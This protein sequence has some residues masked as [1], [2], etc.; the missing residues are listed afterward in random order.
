MAAKVMAYRIPCDEDA[1]I[2]RIDVED[3]YNGVTD[4]VFGEDT[5][6]HDDR[7]CGIS[8]FRHAGVQLVYDDNGL[9]RAGPCTNVRAMHTWAYLA[10]M[11][12]HEFVTPLVGDFVVLGLE[13]ETGETADVPVDV[14]A[15]LES[16][17]K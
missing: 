14:A 7:V 4:A 16:R 5:G 12:L 8:T 17:F 1:P 2:E 15:W 6:H 11:S 13:G 9:L 3:S 10:G